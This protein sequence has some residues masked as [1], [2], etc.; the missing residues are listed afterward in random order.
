MLK[1]I[2]QRKTEHSYSTEYLIQKMNKIIKLSF[3]APVFSCGAFSIG[4]AFFTMLGEPD[5]EGVMHGS[6][7]DI[8]KYIREC[9]LEDIKG[10]I[11]YIND[12]Q[13]EL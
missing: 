9:S 10:R 13:D 6:E 11:K 1:L 8:L 2:K 12:I 5:N 4:T 7:E 3:S